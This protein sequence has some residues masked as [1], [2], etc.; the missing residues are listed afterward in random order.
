MVLFEAEADI[1][2]GSTFDFT[3]KSMIS[4]IAPNWT[5]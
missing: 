1:E 3:T 5:F 4:W 2:D